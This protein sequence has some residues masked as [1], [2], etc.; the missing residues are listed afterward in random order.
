MLEIEIEW[1]EIQWEPLVASMVGLT[2][3]RV[4]FRVLNR[5]SAE[6]KDALEKQRVYGWLQEVTISENT[7]MNWRSTRAIASYNNLAVDRARY[8]CNYHDGIVQHSKE[9]ELW[10]IKGIVKDEV[11]AV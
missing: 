11:V 5:I 9:K 1:T 2:A 6:R 7:L 8:L 4:I 3:T 10:G